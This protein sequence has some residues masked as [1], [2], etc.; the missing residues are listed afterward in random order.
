MASHPR[1]KPTGST[2]P[3]ERGQDHV[4]GYDRQVPAVHDR[5]MSTG[6]RSTRDVCV[7]GSQA[8]RFPFGSWIAEAVP[9][10]ARRQVDRFACSGAL[11]ES[12]GMLQVKHTPLR[13]E[14]H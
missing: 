3:D 4:L 10:R 1:V 13:A 11:T 7:D 6:G 8:R 14:H 9:A 5:K 12:L 2:S